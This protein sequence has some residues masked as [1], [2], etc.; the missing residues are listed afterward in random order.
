[1]NNRS[2]FGRCSPKIKK[3]QKGSVT[4]KQLNRSAIKIPRPKTNH[5]FNRLAL[6][7]SHAYF[8]DHGQPFQNCD[9]NVL[10]V[11]Q[12]Q[13]DL[14]QRARQSKTNLKQPHL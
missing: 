2:L 13:Y 12:D 3:Y 9:S 14:I 11:N 8:D 5:D 7:E 4:M 6:Q 10:I 1:M